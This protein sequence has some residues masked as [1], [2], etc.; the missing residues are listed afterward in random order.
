MRN[1]IISLLVALLLA[2][3]VFSGLVACSPD[4]SNNPPNNPPTS[5]GI[6]TISST[7]L[8]GKIANFMEAQALGVVDKNDQ[9]STFSAGGFGNGTFSASPFDQD[10]SE[11]NVVQKKN[12]LVKETNNGN[13]DVCFHDGG[14]HAKSFKELNKKFNKHH[15]KGVEC[16][17]AECE[18]ISDEIEAQETSGEVE[19]IISLDARVNKLYNYGDFTFMSVS[20]AV[21]GALRVVVQKDRIRMMVAADGLDVLVN[22]GTSG[23][24]IQ[25]GV[26]FITVPS[27]GNIPSSV[28]FVK[29]FE[30]DSDYHK[31]N[32]WSNAYNQSYVIDNKT[33]KTYSLSQFP[34]IYSVEN[35]I[36]KVYNETANGK[37]DYYELSIQNEQL[38][39]NK[40]QLPTQSEANISYN[41]YANNILLDKH[42]HL[43]I[44]NNVR[45]NDPSFDQNGEKKIG[46]KVIVSVALESKCQQILSQTQDRNFANR[47]LQRYIRAKKYHKGSD[48]RIYRLDFNGS[49]SEIKVDVL[50]QNGTWQRVDND[51]NVTFDNG[52]GYIMWMYSDLS[53]VMD[54]F[55]I[56]KISGGYAYYSSAAATDGGRV[57]DCHN[58]PASDVLNGDYVGVVKIPVGGPVVSQNG[59]PYK[60]LELFREWDYKYAMEFRGFNVFL[61]GDTQML[62]L[63]ASNKKTEGVA[64]LM[65]V[66]T[67][68]TKELDYTK[69]IDST[70]ESVKF[71]GY[72]WLNLSKELDVETFG[73][74]S[75]TLEPQDFGGGLDAYFKLITNK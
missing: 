27:K 5:G 33:G 15:H 29:Q 43:V 18:E 61:V 14:Q 59:V 21:E 30:N 56:T 42:G 6:K 44:E 71:E 73:V 72:G 48:D 53:L 39:F 54:S 7:L 23:E 75:F 47:M 11:E 3:A 25:R 65:D 37:F 2:M 10:N 62:Y 52:N 13:K 35:G 40:I 74:N 20:S 50:T 66:T 45:T 22:P 69:V 16:P 67:G 8:D 24:A 46:D 58:M 70:K 68:Q 32:Y 64:C 49:L 55:L 51:T 38:S 36:I 9:A 34:Y 4:S 63:R 28:I 57:W 26:A 60:H 12:E 19:T 31:S 17:H 41:P 1:K